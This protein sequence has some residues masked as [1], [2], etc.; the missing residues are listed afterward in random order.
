MTL[1]AHSVSSFFLVKNLEAQGVDCFSLFIRLVPFQILTINQ[2][3]HR[4][5]RCTQKMPAS[6]FPLLVSSQ[7][8]ARHQLPT[9]RV[10]I[11]CLLFMFTSKASMSTVLSVN[12]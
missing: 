7:V 8:A 10:K 2:V 11:F 3:E 6:I 9:K 5:S 12:S 4:E 1:S